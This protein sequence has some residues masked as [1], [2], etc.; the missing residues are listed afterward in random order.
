MKLF[1]YEH[2]SGPVHEVEVT[3]GDTVLQLKSKIEQA[4]SYT[5]VIEA[6]KQHLSFR[7][8]KLDDDA[9][10]LEAVGVAPDFT[11]RTQSVTVSDK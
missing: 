7:G 2:P 10:T 3:L 11:L 1:A 5:K 9:A 4:M 8:K 6:K